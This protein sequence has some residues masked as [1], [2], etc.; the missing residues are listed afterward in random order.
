MF[1]SMREQGGTAALGA[2]RSLRDHLRIGRQAESVGKRFGNCATTQ[3]SLSPLRAQMR[4][5][6]YPAL[7]P[8]A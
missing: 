8:E 1:D 7:R 2:G 3:Q 4:P 5:H 6:R